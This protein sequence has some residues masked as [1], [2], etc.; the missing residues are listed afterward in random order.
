MVN[1]PFIPLFLPSSLFIL[2][3]RPSKDV[4]RDEPGWHLDQEVGLQDRFMV[5]VLTDGTCA[6]RWQPR[7]P[8]LEPCAALATGAAAEAMLQRL[9]T[10]DDEA[11]SRLAGASQGRQVVVL[12]GPQVHLPWVDG[13][14]YLGLDQRAPGLRLPTTLE[15]VSVAIQLFERCLRLSFAEAAAVGPLGVAPAAAGERSLLVLP[16]G[17]C[18][19]LARARLEALVAP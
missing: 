9:R 12:S 19:P 14:V 17:R 2:P 11:L 10:L 1:Q 16:L 8:P 3:I 6:I 18:L 4:V 15:P 7:E 5:N 13:I